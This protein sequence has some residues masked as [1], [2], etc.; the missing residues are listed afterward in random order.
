LIHRAIE[1][2]TADYPQLEE[3]VDNPM[4][5]SPLRWGLAAKPESPAAVTVIA[6]DGDSPGGGLTTRLRRP[7]SGCGIPTSPFPTRTRCRRR[8]GV[9]GGQQVKPF[10][11]GPSRR[12]RGRH[13]ADRDLSYAR[14]GEFTAAATPISTRRQLAGLKPTPIRLMGKSPRL[15]PVRQILRSQKG[16]ER[17]PHRIQFHTI[18]RRFWDR[19]WGR[20]IAVG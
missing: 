6:E 12:N 4:K 8:C 18:D 9:S 14:R 19:R 5:S 11:G 10:H 16:T 3:L 17:P 1:L 7:A 15:L 20:A 13:R 2:S